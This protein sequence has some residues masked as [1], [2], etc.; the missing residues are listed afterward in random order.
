MVRQEQDIDRRISGLFGSLAAALS[1][2]PSQR[3]DAAIERLRAEADALRTARQ[4]LHGEIQANFPDYA[5]LLSPGPVAANEVR[6]ALAPGETLVAY[7]TGERETFVWA[8]SPGRPTAFAAIPLPSSEAQRIAGQLRAALD[9]QVQF[10]GDIP[11]FNVALAHE[12]HE[13]LLRPVESGWSGARSMFVVPHGPLAQVPFAV[14]VSRPSVLGRE[15]EGR[16]LFSPYRAVSWLARDVALAQLPAAAALPMLRRI[17]PASASRQAFLG[18]GDPVFGTAALVPTVAQDTVVARGGVSVATRAARLVRRNVPATSGLSTAQLASLPPLPDT[19]EEVRSIAQALGADPVNDVRL[20]T[21]ASERSV[22]D[23][24]LMRR[25]VIMFAT[26]GLVPGDLDGLTLPALAMANPHSS[27]VGD[28]GLLT[29]DEVFALRM[30][31][32][33]VVLSACNTASGNGDGAEAISGLGRAFFY[34]GTRALL[35]SNWPV[36]TTSARELTTDLFRRQAA[37]ESPSRAEAMRET[38]VA[39]ITEGGLTDPSTGRTVFSYA[40]PIFWAPFVLVGDAGR[41]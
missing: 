21:A 3:D 30:D 23:A 24:D 41:Q 40:H 33:W 20:G 9:P 10:L 39:M 2:A 28:D 31:A 27:D 12:H 34:A 13:M 22:R 29:M 15:I 8:V 7:Y 1:L 26:H 35:I 16:P 19:A 25:K 11:E 4:V 18:F 6:A 36:E 38:L 14:L 5:K 32:D 37:A 17:P